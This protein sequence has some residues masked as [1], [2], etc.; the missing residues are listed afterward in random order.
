MNKHFFYK[1]I[2]S[3]I[4]L[5][6]SLTIS[7][8]NHTNQITIRSDRVFMLNGKPFFPVGVCFELG[9]NAY[10]QEFKK[11]GGNGTYGFN[12]INLFTQNANLYNCFNSKN[13]ISGDLHSGS[14]Y[15]S[16][17]GL[18]WDSSM[19]YQSNYDRI[20]SYLDTGVYLLS[21]E[22]AFRPD[23]V[24]HWIWNARTLCYDS[25]ILNPPFDQH[26][27]NDAIDRIN[28][29]ALRENSKF[30]GFYSHDDAN[31][32]QAQGPEP[33]MY[34]Y[35]NY[36][37]IRIINFQ[38]S[39]NYAKEVYPNSMVLMSLPPTFFPR[40]FDNNNW[41]DVIAARNAWVIDAIE[42]SKGAN[43]LFSPGSITQEGFSSSFRIYETNFPKWFP[44]HIKETLID[45]VLSSSIEPK[46]V[47]GGVIFDVW[48]NNPLWNDPKMDDKVKWEIYVGLQK[49]AT[50]LIF[51][52]WHK[53]DE[54]FIDHATGQRVYYRPI[55]N[56]VRNQADTLV[57]IKH[58]DRI[59]T[60]TNFGETGYSIIS[61]NPVG[62][63]SY[64]IYKDNASSWSDYYLLLTNNPNG[65]L[66]GPD[67]GNTV[68]TLNCTAHN[69]L[70]YSVKEVFSNNDIRQSGTNTFSY[71]LPWFG[72]AMFR[73][74]NFNHPVIHPG[75]FFI[76]QNYP[77]PF[78]PVTRIK[79]GINKNVF[80]TIELYDGIGRFIKTLVNENHA[81]GV[82][83][84]IFDGTD[85]SSGIYFYKM[86]ATGFEQ[87][88]KMLLVK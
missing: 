78:N 49:G 11:P 35:N 86:K 79:Y 61:S 69:L 29:L 9:E 40:V 75:E 53:K 15:N 32:F 22:L 5:Y 88:M 74:T 8:V 31:M 44:Q 6:T 3:L 25:I 21:D 41:Q 77:N 48:Q 50:G 87:T 39:Y 28:N 17:L 56:A 81:P 65:S 7:Q 23:D 12:F 16:I 14:Q 73:I 24:S 64:A 47:L 38:D 26:A 13:V 52:G 57:N 4:V 62:S 33:P 18:Y 72:T 19:T 66:Y 42:L 34:Y 85:F 67:E 68:V 55:W 45:R 2:F 51:F 76:N 59:F 80:V 30:I 43:V 70:G 58:L 60:K 83:E 36:K 46:A 1:V 71:T 63:V 10:I 37:N 82:Y 84:L 27:R 20:N 54:D